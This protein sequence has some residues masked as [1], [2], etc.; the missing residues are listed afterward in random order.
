MTTCATCRLDPCECSEPSD[1]WLFKDD[2]P[3]MTPAQFLEWHRETFG[4]DFTSPVETH[5]PW[6]DIV[7][8]IKMVLL[9]L[10]VT[11]VRAE[12]LARQVLPMLRSPDARARGG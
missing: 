9:L 11:S 2:E 5:V 4:E 12:D 10:D 3:V 1:A 6:A 8:I 7:T